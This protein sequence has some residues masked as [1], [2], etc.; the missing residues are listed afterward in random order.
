MA[1]NGVGATVE[2]LERWDHTAMMDTDEEGGEELGWQLP[3]QLGA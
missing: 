2:R 1:Q 3:G